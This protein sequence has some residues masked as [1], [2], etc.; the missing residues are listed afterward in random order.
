[1]QPFWAI[2]LQNGHDQSDRWQ[3][4]FGYCIRGE[5]KVVF[6]VD[7]V[8]Q[9]AESWHDQI[10]F[11]GSKFV[12]PDVMLR[13][14]GNEIDG[15]RARRM[16]V[17]DFDEE[18]ATG[19]VRL[20]IFEESYGA[21]LFEDPH[22]LQSLCGEA[23]PVMA[24][25]DL[26][27]ARAL[28]HR[29]Q[30]RPPAGQMRFL[31]MEMSVE[32][33][34]AMMRMLLSG[35]IM[36]PAALVAGPEPAPGPAQAGAGAVPEP[37][38]CSNLTRRENEVLRLA[39]RGQRNKVIADALGLSEHTVKLHIHHIIAKLGVANRTEAATRYLTGQGREP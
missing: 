30:D 21:R 13:L 9:P 1:M 24:Y 3:P 12:F 5:G 10:V 18:G 33:L 14:V 17:A 25:R 31:P 19:P 8:V 6:A 28:L 27:L 11:I 34:V 4:I 37:Q 22:R 23:V 16:E 29:Q 15:A 7:T 2:L 38:P 32:A 20:L 36:V 35:E 26:T 39:A